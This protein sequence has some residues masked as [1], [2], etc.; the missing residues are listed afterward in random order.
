MLLEASERLWIQQGLDS[1]VLSSTDRPMVLDS[2]VRMVS[3]SEERALTNRESN[4]V[5]SFDKLI[6]CLYFVQILN[7][8]YST[9]YSQTRSGCE[10]GIRPRSGLM[11]SIQS[12]VL[13]QTFVECPLHV[14]STRLFLF[15]SRTRT[16]NCKMFQRLKYSELLILYLIHLIS[17]IKCVS[18]IITTMSRQNETYFFQLF[19]F[20]SGGLD[21]Q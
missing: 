7:S 8:L 4:L 15:V 17:L 21:R 13:T 2:T 10:Y 11:Y 9:S 6:K 16:I 14:H 12:I 5:S 19:S 20:F 3:Q 1:M 18:I